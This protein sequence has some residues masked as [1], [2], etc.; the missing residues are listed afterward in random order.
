MD[1]KTTSLPQLSLFSPPVLQKNIDRQYYMDYRPVNQ[2]TDDGPILFD[3]NEQKH[4][5]DLYNSQL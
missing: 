1:L 5:L 3:I 2:L 4:F